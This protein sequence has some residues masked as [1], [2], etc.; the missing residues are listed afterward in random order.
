MARSKTRN[1]EGHGEDRRNRVYKCP[2]SAFVAI[3]Y[4]V[5]KAEGT[6]DD[7]VDAVREQFD[8]RQDAV[9]GEFPEFTREKCKQKC[10]R[11]IARAEKL[12]KTDKSVNVPLRLPGHADLGS[13]LVALEW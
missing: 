4:G 13:E 3:W 6:L 2:Q 10:D 12:A 1:E 7:L 9:K 11:I 5:H 8:S